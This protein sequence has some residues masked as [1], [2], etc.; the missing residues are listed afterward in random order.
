MRGDLLG[1]SIL[2]HRRPMERTDVGGGVDVARGIGIRVAK[3]VQRCADL[4]AHAAAPTA[5]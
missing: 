5:A 4:L 2:V 3:P 1:D